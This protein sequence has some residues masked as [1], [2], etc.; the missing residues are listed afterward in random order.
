M[1]GKLKVHFGTL[2][3][4]SDELDSIAK[5]LQ[6]HL[7]ELDQ[8]VRRVS[9]TWEGDAQGAFGSYYQ[10]WRS[11]SRSLHRAV[12]ALHKTVHTAH[13][14]YSAAR[15]ANVRMWGGGR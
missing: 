7:T 3:E 6:E 14:N 12:R 2:A 13:G 1:S 8:A 4:A 9:E 11:A 10:Q 5:S 15:S